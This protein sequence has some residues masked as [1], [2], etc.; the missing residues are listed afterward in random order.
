M[1]AKGLGVLIYFDLASF[2]PN[3]DSYI[4]DKLSAFH[5]LLAGAIHVRSTTGIQ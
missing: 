3:S 1:V 2:G 4:L 5:L